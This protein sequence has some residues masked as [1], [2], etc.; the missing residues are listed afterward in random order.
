MNIHNNMRIKNSSN[1]STKSHNHIIKFMQSTPVTTTSEITEKFTLSWNTAQTRLLE[2]A[3]EN[4]VE[5][6]GHHLLFCCRWCVS[7]HK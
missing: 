4:K 5:R 1:N 7:C 3:L 2:L 6:I